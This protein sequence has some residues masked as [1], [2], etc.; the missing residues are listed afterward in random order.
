[1]EL[2]VHADITDEAQT[3]TIDV[4]RIG[5]TATDGLDGDKTVI[6]DHQASITDTV[7][8]EG[9]LS[10]I[11]YTMA[12]I[13]MDADTGLPIL[14]G[15]ARE[16][17]TDEDVT[18]FMEQVADALGVTTDDDGNVVL[19]ADVDV[20]V[21]NQLLA[22]NAELASYLVY[23]T[24]V[25]TPET[26]EGTV[27]MDFAFNANDVI[28]RLSGETKNVVVFEVMLKGSLDAEEGSDVTLVANHTDLDD[29][30]QTV[31]LAPSRIFTVATDK[32]DSDHTLMPG[33]DAVITDTVNYEGLIP[34]EEY[35]LKATLYDKET[36]EPLSVNDKSVTA[37]LRFTPNSQNGSVDIDLG[38][39]DASELNG[40]TLVVFEELY[41]QSTVDG[42]TTDVLVAEHKDIN[43]EGQSVLVTDSPAGNTIEK[44]DTTGGFFGKTGGN[45]FA[46]AAVIVVLLVAAGGLTF[47]GIRKRS[48]AE[49]ASEVEK[50]VVKPD[51]GSDA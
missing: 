43:D 13:L 17:F 44:D 10:G 38:P 12:G 33:Q 46:L 26:A 2:A 20:A 6:A 22:D 42:D 23:T 3:V 18:A 25:F 5:T 41:K 47:Y 27:S 48:A 28:D 34:G 40:H 30:G 4:T 37:E 21:L 39:F 51:D 1:M 7:A 19:P 11:E 35:V 50:T 16:K 36:G 24:S 8:Y 15:N 14:T 45:L 9:A 31:V 49:S 32:S 29:E